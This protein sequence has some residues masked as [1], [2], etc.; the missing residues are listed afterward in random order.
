M[1]FCLTKG[2][3]FSEIWDYQSSDL[4]Y[5][6]SLILATIRPPMNRSTFLSLLAI[7]LLGNS[8]AMGQ[9]ASVPPPP[10][11][12]LMPSSASSE[13]AQPRLASASMSPAP[14]TA[15]SSAAASVSDPQAYTMGSLA[16]PA[17]TQDI[18]PST[19]SWRPDLTF[20]TNR[21]RWSV[22]VEALWLENYVGRGVFLGNTDSYRWNQQY[23]GMWTD[24][25]A[26]GLQPGIRFQLIGQM[27]DDKAFEAGVWGLQQW[28]TSETI[29]VSRT[30]GHVLAESPYLQGAWLIG[31]FDNF[32]NYT[33][34]SKVASAEVNER[35]NFYSDPFREYSWL[36][37]VRYFHW[38]DDLTLNG[39]DLY[40]Q[41][42]ETLDWQTKNDLVGLQLGLRGVW[43]MNRLEVSTELKG[44]LFANI[45]S[46]QGTNSASGIAGFQA[47]DISHGDTNLAAMLELSLLIRYR[48][49]D[50]V[51]LRGG[52][53]YYGVTGLAIAPRQLSCYDTGGGVGL[54]GLSIGL[55]WTR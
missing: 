53:Q 41:A 28:S 22:N 13:P 16:T 4:T 5:H 25:V 21:P 10:T 42:F 8:S 11:P 50:H 33:Y 24:D 34:K 14:A 38:S 12:E 3:V 48:I 27:G 26:S 1:A 39:S 51:W 37:G 9:A 6:A 40:N 49:A 17:P 43:K 54:D 45:Y 52:Y 7:A 30:N 36:C 29:D 47:F 46:Q 35:F 55:E 2:R 19:P 20:G 31:G 15:T 44:G 18:A 23:G 32:V